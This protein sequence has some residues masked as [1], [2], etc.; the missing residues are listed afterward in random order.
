MTDD[1]K[2]PT[3]DKITRYQPGKKAKYLEKGSKQVEKL[4][5]EAQSEDLSENRS[6][7]ISGRIEMK[8]TEENKDLD[9]ED[10]M[11]MERIQKKTVRLKFDP[12]E[13][14]K[15]FVFRHRTK[16]KQRKEPTVA[17]RHL[18]CLRNLW[19]QARLYIDIFLSPYLHSRLNFQE[20]SG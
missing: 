2:T 9:E 13:A 15:A 17:K 7:S 20:V 14:E 6:T 10:Q 3:D 1:N 8:I 5:Q 19:N 4:K 16:K 11:R 18:S 12:S